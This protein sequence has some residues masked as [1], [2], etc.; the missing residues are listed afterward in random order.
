MPGA[1][2]SVAKKPVAK[3]PADK[4]PTTRRKTAAKAPAKKSPAK[5]RRSKKKPTKKKNSRLPGWLKWLLGFGVKVAIV[6]VA[7]LLVVGIY[8]D[9]V[10]RDKFDGQLWNLP[11]VVYGRVLT[12]QPDQAMTLQEVRRELDLLQYHKVKTPQRIGEYSSS[13]TRIEL[14][15]RPFEFEDGP[16]GKR[17]VML[18]FAD[19]TLSRINEVGSKRQLGYVRIE[20]KMLGM[21]GTSEGEQRIFL[22]RERFPEVLVD[23][24][25]VT[26]DR[27]FYHHGGV[28]PLAIVRALFVNL[29]AGRTVQGGSTLTQ[30]LAKNI[31]LSRE[32]TLLRKLSEAYIALIIDYRYSKDRILEA[33]L[34][35]IYLGQNG[36][37]EVHGF[38]LG[39]RLYFGRP[40]QELRIDQQALLVGLAKGPS[41]YNPWRNPERARQRRD[42][43]L[44]LMMD[45]GILDGEQ[46]E[47]AASR[48]LDVQSR[49]MIASRQPAYFQQLQRE[50]KQ[51]VGD[52]FTPG[53]G[54]RVFSTLDP[55]SQQEAEKAVMTMVPKL[56]KKAGVKVETAIV[57]VDRQ[58]GEVRAMVGGSRPG[59][60]GFNRALDGSRQIG[61]LVKPA[62]YL[63]ALRK[64]GQYTL[65]TTIDDKPIM[66]KGS[67][68]T[69]WKPRNYDRKFRGEVPLYYALAKSLNVP[70]VNLGLQVGLEP[71][72][73]TMVQL[74][75]DRNEIPKLPSILLGAF[76]LTPFEVTQMYQTVT[77]GGRKAELTA[78]RAVVDQ[79]G[80]ML[81]QN[82]PKAAQAVPE[83]AAWLTTYGMKN[84]VS[85]GTARF[86]QPKFGWAALAGKTGTTDKTRDSWYVGADGREVV[87]VWIGRDDNKPVNLTG[88][89]GALRLYSDYLQRRQPEPLHLTWPKKLTT[90]KYNRLSNGTLSLDCSGRQSLPV[91]DK[92]GSLKT[93]CTGN[94]PAAW[95]KDMFSL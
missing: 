95:I 80:S 57:A 73:N 40:L 76:T 42:L 81:Y 66:L 60:A 61:S 15:R 16:E 86:L 25:L 31:F 11:A 29:R 10:V 93:Q 70:T 50:L 28:S 46:Y 91:W 30:Q 38:A 78:L 58:S 94:K 77:S 92:D 56:N 14:I 74:G 35:E 17:H 82:Y 83:Q 34:N 7:I 84:V 8:L 41:Y 37:K 64:P 20:P 85:Q 65:A 18:T 5:P 43:I 3:K 22:P 72:I 49:P 67:R 12:L 13:S 71:V 1:K 88:S 24:L 36:G 69:A 55:L 53:I 19:G 33:Y 6:V 48:P 59:Y 87:T 54:L 21:L 9:N 45:N 62:V 90:M 39:A 52:N 4:K 63:A 27:D 75:V 51:K 47:Q 89:A 32:R 79:Q 2:K 68:G 26:E 23:A 44:R